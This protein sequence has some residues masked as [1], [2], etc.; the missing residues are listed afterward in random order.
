MSYADITRNNKS[1]LKKFSHQKRFDIAMD[2]I[3]L[4]P[5]ETLLDFG[6]GDGYLL[7]CLHEKNAEAKLYG[8]DPLDFMFQELKDTIKKNDLNNIF[9]TDKLQELP[10]N[11][12][13]VVTCL[14]VLEHFSEKNQRERLK[15]L[16]DRV[17]VKG[18]I[19][20]SVPLETGLPSLLKNTVRFLIG[21]NKEEASLKNIVKSLFG[22]KIERQQEGYIYTHIGFNHKHL[23]KLFG[24]LNLKIVRK[25]Y[26][27]FKYLYNLV[28][29]Q[30]FYILKKV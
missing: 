27:P 7:Q 1:S 26:S 8:Y 29:S 17:A 28:N 24:E 18:R 23:E 2:L 10:T 12:F 15:E 5:K 25:E 16:A 21:Q 9:I 20:I 3:D 6:T 14:E 22:I 19:V 13:D 30:V 11:N 4:K